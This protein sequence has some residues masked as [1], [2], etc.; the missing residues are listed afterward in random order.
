M[1]E[2]ISKPPAGDAGAFELGQMLGQRRAFGVVAGRCS[3]ADAACVRRMREEKLYLHRAATWEEFCPRHLGMSKTQANRV[4]RMLEEFGPDY[5]ELAQ[6]ARISP[7]QFRAIAPQVKQGA[8]HVNGAAIALIP[9]NAERV[10][11]AVAALRR[12]TAPPAAEP[13]AR[14]RLATL[15]RR[16]DQATADLAEMSRAELPGEEGLLVASVLRGTLTRLK[17]LEYELRD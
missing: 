3:A 15:E 17:R 8:I 13:S 14:E 16:L 12:E 7:E 2:A 10:A 9:E 1:D 4:I 6:L 11:A 5:F